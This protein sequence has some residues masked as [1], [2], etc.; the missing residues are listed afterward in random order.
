MTLFSYPGVGKIYIWGKVKVTGDNYMYPKPLMDL[1]F[2]LSSLYHIL[3]KTIM[4][5]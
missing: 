2:L 4:A 3:P 1:R 5:K